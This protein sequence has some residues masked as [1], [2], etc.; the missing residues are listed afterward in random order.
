MKI[1]LLLLFCFILHMAQ[2]QE[3]TDEFK[4]YKPCTECFE[5][6]H[7]GSY[8][9]T[10]PQTQPRQNNTFLGPRAR[11]FIRGVV[12]VSVITISAIILTK[13]SQNASH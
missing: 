6:W 3:K 7:N 4:T 9:G 11:N 13:Y 1:L 5:K 10:Q 8:A 2:A 12:A